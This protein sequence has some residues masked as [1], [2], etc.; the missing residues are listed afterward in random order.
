MD[1]MRIN[2]LEQEAVTDPL[3]G[4]FNRRYLDRRLHEEVARARRYSLS[5]SALLLDIDLFKQIND[6]HGHQ[7]GDRVL[8]ELGKMALE[9]LR[10]TD[11][12]ARYGGEEFLILA[13]NTA[14]D[15]ARLVAERLRKR[16]E[17][18]DFD[19][20]SDAK[21]SEALRVTASIGVARLGDGIDTAEKLIRAADEN[22]YRAKH[23]GRNRVVAGMTGSQEAA[24]AS[25]PP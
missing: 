7:A 19:L 11:V 12:L 18:H 23:E 22:L 16:I 17:M 13:P 20:R 14:L 24:P 1:V 5:L 2:L 6:R 9:F 8:L 3:T 10:E 4:V 21:G 25:P 15:D